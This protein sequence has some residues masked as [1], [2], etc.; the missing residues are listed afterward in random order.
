MN[1]TDKEKNE[2]AQQA[3]KAILLNAKLAGIDF[4]NLPKEIRYL[5]VVAYQQGAIDILEKLKKGGDKL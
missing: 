2:I 3:I 1:L 5:I 4:F